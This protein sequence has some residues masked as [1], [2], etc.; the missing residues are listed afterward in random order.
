MDR[1]IRWTESAVED[2]N[3]VAK[4]IAR[5]SPYYAASFVRD[6]RES[7]HSLNVFPERGRIVPEIDTSDIREIF[8]KSYRLIYK[9]TTLDVFILAF[10]H[11]ARDLA[12]LWKHGGG[13]QYG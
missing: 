10:I 6:V 8:I 13:F 2:L 4:F 3:E 1:T 9:V 5:D 11:A 12:A 7:A